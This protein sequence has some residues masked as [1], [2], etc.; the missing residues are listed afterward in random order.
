MS[1]NSR[2]GVVRA[3]IE[4]RWIEKGLA[5]RPTI[6][7]HLLMRFAVELDVEHDGRECSRD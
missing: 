5:D 7:V 2:R 1:T 4:G 3:E 6:D